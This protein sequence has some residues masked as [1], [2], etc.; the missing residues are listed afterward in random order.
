MQKSVKFILAALCLVFLSSFVSGQETKQAAVLLQE[1]RYAEEIDGNLDKAIGIY[2]QIIKDASAD[3][4]IKAQAMY[5]QGLCYM[6]KQETAKAQDVLGKLIEQYPQQDKLIEKAK[7]IIAELIDSDPA[8]L[9]PPETV[10]YFELGSPG[11]QVETILNMLKG[12]PL[13]NP[14]AVMGRGGAQPQGQSPAQVLNAIFNPSMMAEF[15]KIRGMA[16]GFTEIKNNSA[17]GI[18][19]FYPGESDALRGL[20]MA[21]LGIAGKPAESID[22][23]NILSFEDNA[24]VAYDDKVIIVAQPM[25]LLKK[26][27]SLYKRKGSSPNL[28]EN[29]KAFAQIG[30]AVRKQNAI[31]VWVKADQLFQ[32]IKAQEKRPT[33]GMSI[34][35]TFLEPQNIDE[36]IYTLSISNDAINSDAKLTFKSGYQ[37]IAYNMFRTP[38]LT[39]DGFTGVPADAVALMSFALSPNLGEKIQKPLARVT[40]LDIGREIFDN[41]EQ[42]NI[43]ITP[44][45]FSE[46][47]KRMPAALLGCLGISLT[48]KNP[49]QTGQILRTILGTVNTVTS[50]LQG[51]K[52][53]SVSQADKYMLHA[54]GQ[55]LYCYLGQIQNATILTFSPD[56]LKSAQQGKSVLT[57]GPLQNSIVQL[58]PD[59]SKLV[60]LNAGGCVKIAESFVKTSNDNPDNPA[61][62][63]LDQIAAVLDKT[64]LRIQTSEKDDSLA[65]HAGIENIPPLK[66]VFGLVMQYSQSQPTKKTTATNPQPANKTGVPARTSVR[67]Q[68]T[69]GAAA[70]SHKV[71]LGTDPNKLTLLADTNDNSYEIKSPQAEGNYYWRVDEVRADGTVKAGTTWSFRT[72]GLVA[73]WKFDE[74][75]GTVA[76]DSTKN[77]YDAALKGGAKWVS[78]GE[79]GGA[80]SLDGLDGYVELPAGVNQFNGGFTVVLWAKPASIGAWERFFEFGN[81]EQKD[82]I[83]LSRR[84]E[85]DDLSFEIY[86]GD[87]WTGRV[88]APNAIDP[89][90]WQCFAVTVEQNGRAVLYKN[91]KRIAY[92]RTG[93]IGN[94]QRSQLY[95]G[96]SQWPNDEMYKGLID[97]F[98]IYNYVLSDSEIKAIYISTLNP[99]LKTSNAQKSYASGIVAHWK[100]D[101]SEGTVAKDSSPQ[102]KLDGTVKGG[103]QWQSSG[104]QTGGALSFD[105]FDDYIELPTGNDYFTGGP[106]TITLW[107]YPTEALS[108]ERLIEFGNDVYSDNV[109]FARFQTDDS[110]TL[111]IW[112]GPERSQGK[113]G[114]IVAPDMVELNKWQFFAATVDKNGK[115]A[116]YKNGE[117]IEEGDA[118]L[119]RS[120]VRNKNYIGKSLWPNDKMFKGMMDDVRIYNCAL[121]A[122]EIEAVYESA[123]N[124]KAGDAEHK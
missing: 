6:K 111:A 74:N 13:E 68:W 92:G 22:G 46:N 36:F 80:V 78:S 33:E 114:R 16:A 44:A 38:S 76:K 93:D 109:Y 12:T 117:L 43:F 90:N 105:G 45:A 113:W 97:D 48:S 32:A 26:S 17:N 14:L 99:A 29:N 53:Q 10:V 60:L 77:H 112:S 102:H 41:I 55:N 62:K 40:G 82:N 21:G 7:S 3:G 28:A 91:G 96:K 116:I 122:E 1:G 64:I 115:A 23:M 42:V 104:G 63:N 121:D 57:A 72:G 59:T 52:E 85:T 18:I 56:I 54:G 4:A 69:A 95:I 123:L 37:G 71:Y 35:E 119:P 118:L 49:Q 2:E 8:A 47:Q 94:V 86:T 98:R 58:S 5:Q 66:D 39:K 25:D 124:P 103:A 75:A 73:H 30:K 87:Q 27:I 24:G 50:S 51:D 79:I 88:Q 19:V 83:I 89:N 70:V 101:E 100:L 106:F 108:W 34:I 31:T 9:M 84:G 15:K 81:G 110:L 120:V 65:I 20:I 11:K 107:A 67:L 61:Y